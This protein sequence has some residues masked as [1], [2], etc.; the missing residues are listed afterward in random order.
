MKRIDLAN[1]IAKYLNKKIY[2]YGTIGENFNKK[3]K[4]INFCGPYSSNDLSKIM[5]DTSCV[6][7]TSDTE[8]LPYVGLEAI[9][10]LTP[11]IVRNTY[12]NAEFLLK[13]NNGLLLDKKLSA[14][15]I[16]N[17][18]N[19]FFSNKQNYKNAILQTLKFQKELKNYNAV[20]K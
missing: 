9:Q 18:I 12:A 6:L 19:E 20:E 7:I 10:H 4:Y 3:Y 14:K 1:K 16:A 8:G 5:N 17:K 15:K 2:A 13:N 11:L